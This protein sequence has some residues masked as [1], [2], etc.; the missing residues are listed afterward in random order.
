MKSI[1]TLLLFFCSSMYVNAQKINGQWRGY[2]DSNGDIV[3]SGG[4]NTEYILELEIDGSS[5]TGYSYSYFQNRR[6]YVICS[7]TGT[8]YNSS[9]S[10]RVTETARVKGLT[11]P[12]WVDCLQTHILTYEKEG[13]TEMLKGKWK[14]AP[15]QNTDCGMG[16]TTLTRRTVTNDLATYNKSQ[17][18]TPNSVP[19][20]TAKLPANTEK[21]KVN[22]PV[23]KVNPVTKENTPGKSPTVN[24]HTET[25]NGAKENKNTETENPAR[26]NTENPSAPELNFEK[27][28]TEIVKTIEIINETFRVDLYDNGD[29][30]GDSVSLFYNGKLLLSHKRLSDKPI[31]LTL[32]ATTDKQVNE[33]TMY[34]ENLGEIPPNTAVMIVTD[35]DKRYEV[36]ITSDLKKSGTIR[37]VHKE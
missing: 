35:G 12:D 33:L 7:V 24:T 4:S 10:I 14:T 25:E 21:N 36:R 8:Y 6:Y 32:D 15:G 19:K 16:N 22:P 11:P 28:N 27:R 1:F 3:L 30:D 26:K 31:T 18:R 20:T 13:K 9:K 34:A 2:F 29:I 5:V 17:T 37:F 23:A